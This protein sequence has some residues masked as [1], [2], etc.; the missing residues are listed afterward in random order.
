MSGCYDGYSR[1]ELIDLLQKARFEVSDGNGEIEYEDEKIGISED[2]KIGL[3]DLGV[4][5]A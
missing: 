5:L 3:E 1:E 4:V 2:K